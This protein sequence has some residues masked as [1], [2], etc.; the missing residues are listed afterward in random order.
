MPRDERSA[1]LEPYP[2]CTAISTLFHHHPLAGVM[3]FSQRRRKIPG[4]CACGDEG[5]RE[6]CLASSLP[7]LMVCLYYI[8]TD[9]NFPLGPVFVLL[10]LYAGAMLEQSRTD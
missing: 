10:L 3:L 9:L 5:G 6:R 2:T 7:S 8:P 4:P 1:P